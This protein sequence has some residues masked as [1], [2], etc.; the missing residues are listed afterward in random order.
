MDARWVVAK[1]G[2]SFPQRGNSY[3]N[4]YVRN[5]QTSA[6]NGKN[7][8]FSKFP[9]LCEKP[10]QYQSLA[11]RYHT[12][13]WKSQFC[14]IQ[15]RPSAPSTNLVSNWA[16]DLDGANV[17]NLTSFEAANDMQLAKKLGEI[18]K[19]RRNCKIYRNLMTNILL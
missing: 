3:A 10:E 5:Q 6:Q 8:L 7:N 19:E 11:A 18:D 12:T 14:D 1:T 16:G 13:E 4:G 15:R 9:D 17:F 2:T